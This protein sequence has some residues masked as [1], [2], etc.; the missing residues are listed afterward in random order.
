MKIKTERRYKHPKICLCRRCSGAGF[1]TK[2][3]EW[4]ENEIIETCPDCEGSGR[5]KVS[6]I[7]E[8]TIEPY[9]PL[10]KKEPN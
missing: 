1:I 10:M 5:V 3:D 4:E 2:L 7:R 9:V 8:V 6:A